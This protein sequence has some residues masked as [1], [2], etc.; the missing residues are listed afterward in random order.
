MSSFSLS[1]GT[2]FATGLPCFVI[3]TVSRLACTSSITAR[4]WILKEPA[5]IFFIPN[6]LDHGH[7]TIV[8]FAGSF[9]LTNRPAQKGRDQQ[10]ERVNLERAS[11]CQ[12]GAT[13]NLS[14]CDI[15]GRQ[16][17][18]FPQAGEGADAEGRNRF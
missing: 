12:G 3:K 13:L 6:L 10:K 9:A 8:L 15:A 14:T 17:V 5:A 11:G 18:R 1:A 2:S 4:Q 16:R 7:Y